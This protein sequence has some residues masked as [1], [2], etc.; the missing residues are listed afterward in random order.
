MGPRAIRA[1]IRRRYRVPAAACRNSRSYQLLC[2]TTMI[3]SCGLAFSGFSWLIWSPMCTTACSG[4]ACG[5]RRARITASRP[6]EAALFL[7]GGVR[8]RLGR[9]GRDGGARAFGLPALGAGEHL[10]PDRPRPLGLLRAA[11]PHR[12]GAGEM[13]LV[14]PRHGTGD[15]RPS[16]RERPL[17]GTP[18]T[19]RRAADAGGADAPRSRSRRGRIGIEAW[20]C[21]P[22]AW[23]GRDAA[24]RPPGRRL[25]R[26][27]PAS[28]TRFAW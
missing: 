22:A 12:P 21:G 26:T 6:A 4:D 24:A 11:P 18:R 2:T 7:R 19:A 14:D 15:G 23:P 1:P 3:L 13:V 27:S 10:L 28:S 17:R 25:D 5:R 8:A 20:S 16:G 9:C